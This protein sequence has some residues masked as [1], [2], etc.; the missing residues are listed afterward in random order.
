MPELGTGVNPLMC[1]FRMSLFLSDLSE[2][3][4][5]PFTPNTDPSNFVTF[6]YNETLDI[7]LDIKH[8]GYIDISWLIF[9]YA[10]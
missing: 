9:T 6:A 10:A 5:L 8:P 7:L 1:L 4:P 2:K 3:S